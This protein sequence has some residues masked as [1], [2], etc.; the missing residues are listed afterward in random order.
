M[1]FQ[2]H[3][4]DHLIAAI[5]RR[6]PLA[7]VL[8][9]FSLLRAAS[10]LFCL[11]PLELLA[12]TYLLNLL[13]WDIFSNSIDE[14]VDQMNDL[15]WCGRED[16]NSKRTGLLFLLT[17]CWAKTCFSDNCGPFLAEANKM[18]KGF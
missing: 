4:L 8:P 18:C 10:R 15:F 13:K 9:P 2:T 11:T 17:S 7:T 16:K 6:S 1:K 12:A 3:S 5:A 14:H